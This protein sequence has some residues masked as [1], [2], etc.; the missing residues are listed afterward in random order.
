MEFYEQTEADAK[1][2]QGAAEKVVAEYEGK[3]GK[4]II[5]KLKAMND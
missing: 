5:T 1:A 2:F 3:V 4:D